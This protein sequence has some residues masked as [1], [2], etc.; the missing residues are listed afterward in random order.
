MLMRE[1]YDTMIY[2]AEDAVS[3]STTRLITA[4]VTSLDV[5]GPTSSPVEALAAVHYFASP[6]EKSNSVRYL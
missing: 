6:I 3:P 4:G 2:F 5:L 1:H